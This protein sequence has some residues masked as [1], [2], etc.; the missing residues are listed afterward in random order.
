MAVE[1]PALPARKLDQHH[2]RVL[3]H[4]LEHDAFAVPRH[5]E[6]VRE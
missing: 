5:I 4:A 3:P 1:G 6:A 2:V